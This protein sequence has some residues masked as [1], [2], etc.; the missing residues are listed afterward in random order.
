MVGRG[1]IV[2]SGGG[3][4]GFTRIVWVG[5]DVSEGMGRAVSPG[6]NVGSGVIWPSDDGAAVCVAVASGLGSTVGEDVDREAMGLPVSSQHFS[7]PAT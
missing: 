7:S 5:L 1:Q 6:S 4:V 3:I 2:S